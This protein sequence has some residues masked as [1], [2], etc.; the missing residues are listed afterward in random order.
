MYLTHLSLTD[1]RNYA[2]MDEQAP[3]GALILVGDNAQGKTSLLEAVYCLAT[4]VSFN[5]THDRQL[6]RMTDTKESIAVARIVASFQ[7]QSPPGIQQSNKPHKL[8]VRII[9]EETGVNGGVRVRKEIL[10]DGQKR[11]ASETLGAFNAVLFLPQMLRVIEGSPEERRRYLN[12]SIAQVTPLYGETLS[13]YH[14]LLTQRNALLKNLAERGADRDTASRQLEY[15]DE[16]LA[17][18]GAFLIHARIQAV[19]EL[20]RLAANIHRDL[21]QGSEV[22]RLSY[23]PAFEPL[24]SSSTGQ[25][26]LPLDDPRDR[27]NLGV[28]QIRDRYL[29]WLARN[30]SEE[31]SHGITITGPHRDELRFLSNKLDLGTYGSRGQARTAVLSLKFAEVEWMKER[32]GESPVLLLDEVLAEL[33]PT[34]RS[35]LL[36]RLMSSDQVWMT[37]TD[38]DAFSTDFIQSSKLWQ[39]RAGEILKSPNLSA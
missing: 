19:H 5:A 8:E 4:F 15:W 39:I 35:D 21:T 25:I 28:E 23:Q 30:R 3:R 16:H 20:E 9:Q 6:I 32:T 22:L 17:I 24:P 36:T 31:L 13:K 12:L 38:L 33:D 10:L 7:R 26:A 27:S 1:Y 11:K 18:A 14:Q 34:R 29:H 2:R 37:T